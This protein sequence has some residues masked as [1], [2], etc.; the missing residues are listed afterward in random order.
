M[1][2]NPELL[3]ASDRMCVGL[4]VQCMFQCRVHNLN[5]EPCAHRARTVCAPCDNAPLVCVKVEEELDLVE[6]VE[7]E[8]DRLFE[9]RIFTVGNHPISHFSSILHFIIFLS[10]GA[11]CPPH[12]SPSNSNGQWGGSNI[13]IVRLDSRISDIHQ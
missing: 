10:L 11:H 13:C 5:I 12:P 1:D 6:Y 9:L 8:C 3:L 7:L 4:V 2:L